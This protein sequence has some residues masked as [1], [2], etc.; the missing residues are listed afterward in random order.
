ML[1]GWIFTNSVERQE[2]LPKLVN[3]YLFN[4]QI[5][6]VTAIGVST[7]INDPGLW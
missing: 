2:F 3:V 1:D 7:L 4:Y 6:L 5:D